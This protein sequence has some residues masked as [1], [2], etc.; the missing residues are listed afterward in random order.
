M[1]RGQMVLE[2]PGLVAGFTF[3]AG[4]PWHELTCVV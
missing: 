3:D 1:A 2:A 4:M